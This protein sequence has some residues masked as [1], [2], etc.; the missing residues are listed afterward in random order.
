M[1]N[2]VNRDNKKSVKMTSEKIKKLR[3]L[4]SSGNYT[5]KELATK[6]NITITTAM[7]YK[8]GVPKPKPL[9][10]KQK[11]FLKEK[12]RLKTKEAIVI[13]G[14]KCMSCGEQYNN[15]SNYSNLHFDHKFYTDEE[16]AIMTKDNLTR[17]RPWKV[18]KEPERFNLLCRPCHSMISFG[19]KYPNKLKS[20]MDFI[21]NSK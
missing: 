10:E 12:K 20:S 15:D 14:G 16:I 5:W 4:Y 19:R 18:I 3:E 1:L 2:R 6:F 21:A 7:K 9:T 13:L 8:N 11:Q 17:N